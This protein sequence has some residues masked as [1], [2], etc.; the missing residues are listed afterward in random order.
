[1]VTPVQ[2]RDLMLSAGDKPPHQLIPDKSVPADNKNTP[3]AVASLFTHEYSPVWRFAAD[4]IIIEGMNVVKVEIRD[5][6]YGQ[7]LF[8]E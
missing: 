1:M 3:H 8:C 7:D 6:P 5:G 2:D 4:Q